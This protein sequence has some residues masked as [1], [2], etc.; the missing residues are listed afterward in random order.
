MSCF[1]SQVTKRDLFCVK[2]EYERTNSEKRDT[3][4]RSLSLAIPLSRPCR[5]P[6]SLYRSLPLSPSL[7]LPFF[8]SF[9]LPFRLFFRLL[10]FSCLHFPIIGSSSHLF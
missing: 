5:L 3:L 8:L 7:S 6:L 1:Q 9:S 2:F 10:L 4:F